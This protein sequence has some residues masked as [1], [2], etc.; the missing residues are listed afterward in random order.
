VSPVP[1][2]VGRS[3]HWLIA[4]LRRR[5][6]LHRIAKEALVG[7]KLVRQR[8]LR[9]DRERLHAWGER[10]DRYPIPFAGANID[11]LR[12]ALRAASLRFAEGRHTLY[13]PPQPGREAVFGAELLA[14]FPPEAGIKVLKNFDAPSR[15]RYSFESSSA[16][17]DALLGP[18]GNQGFNAAALYAYELG[19]R[20]YDIVHLRGAAESSGQAVDMTAIVAEHIDG[21]VPSEAEH[22]G[23]IA[24]LQRL[25]QRGVFRF[26][27]H[28]GYDNGDFAGPG[29]N[30]NLITGPGGPRYVDTQVFDFAGE[31]VIEDVLATRE[32]VLHFGD[33]LTIVNAGQRFL[34]QAV[35]GAKS[36]ARRGTGERWQTLDGLL[37]RHQVRFDGRAVFD[38]CCNSGM[39]MHG[40]LARGGHWAFGWDLPAVAE[41]AD[42][43]LPLIGA[44]RTTLFGRQLD[45]DTEFDADLP[46]W[47]MQWGRAHGGVALF[48]A[49]WH[50][51]GFPARIGA[52]PWTHM[53]Y[54]GSENEADE[55]TAANLVTMAER[56]GVR[57]LE[58]VIIRDG[59]CGPRPV[60][61]LARARPN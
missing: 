42:R 17:E 33:V 22:Q 51:I 48:L 1:R 2:F 20:P 27:G 31:Q 52:L 58:R 40:A 56:W 57:E 61:L 28:S 34:Y 38:I 14:A 60:L 54:E 12:V 13:V 26:L 5:P 15:V 44:G 35:P 37:A 43:L 3:K 10:S 11:A 8:V 19:P 53:I 29:C 16:A 55:T 9:R 23:F 59:I 46:A 49:A 39:M 45:L 18:I 32:D 4:N 36:N 47:A 6:I 30:D 25:E 7:A 24:A 21:R 50:H 41:A